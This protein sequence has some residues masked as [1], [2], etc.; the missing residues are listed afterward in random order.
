V[1]NHPAVM[2]RFLTNP[3]NLGVWAAI[4]VAIH[5]L[6][7]NWKWGRSFWHRRLV[8]LGLK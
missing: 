8:W 6:L 1:L 7:W 3:V 5:F 2:L 4:M